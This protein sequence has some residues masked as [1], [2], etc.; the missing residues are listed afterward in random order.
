MLSPHF[1]HLHKHEV[2]VVA[3][4]VALSQDLTES[5]RFKAEIAGM[6]PPA[7]K[8]FFSAE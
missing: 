8:A 7:K 2:G 3:L 5:W 6:F 4:V 1:H